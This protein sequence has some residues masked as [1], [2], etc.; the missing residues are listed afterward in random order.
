MA[1]EFRANETVPEALRR[2]AREQLDRA[3]YELTHE[4]R[5]DPVEAVHAARKA[6]KKER[7]LLR[8]GRAALPSR[9]RGRENS[10]LR[11]AARRMAAARDSEV[12]VQSLDQLAERY[13]G[14][15][16]ASTFDAAR[17]RLELDRD[18]QIAETSP[19]SSAD[20]AAEQIRAVRLRVDSWR[21]KGEGWS[22]IEPG[23]SR[24][25]SEGRRAF[26]RARKSSS[27]EDLHAWRKRVKDLWYELRLLSPVCGPIIAGG[28]EEADRL[29]EL[30][31]SEHDLGLLKQAL[32]RKAPEVPTHLDALIALVE[33][34][35]EQ[36]RRQAFLVGKRL[37]NE[38]TSDFTR[39]LRKCWDAGRAEYQELEAS[40]P[41]KPGQT[42]HAADRAPQ[43]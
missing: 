20:E 30:L 14:Q 39:R 15:L 6:I 41:G 22:A 38:P 35:R 28:A 4:I 40:R 29:G 43:A 21:L 33:Y 16:P 31:G 25:Y 24:T 5:S 7:A 19:V 42:A 32:I 23:L 2:C 36:L 3:S 13:A 12:V 1:Y 26:R 27:L 8:L 10:A 34:R 18:A 9:R 17:T 37:Y 11:N